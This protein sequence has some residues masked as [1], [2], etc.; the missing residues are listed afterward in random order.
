M[1]S[2]TMTTAPATDTPDNAGGAAA[3]AAAN[4]N[5]NAAPSAKAKAALS[6]GSSVAQPPSKE[7][8]PESSTGGANAEPATFLMQAVQV[9]EKKVRNLEKRKVRIERHYETFFRVHARGNLFSREMVD[10]R[11]SMVDGVV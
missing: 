6:A 9:T 10:I 1:P 4:A 5:S 11:P 3:A 2:L 7:A 8:T